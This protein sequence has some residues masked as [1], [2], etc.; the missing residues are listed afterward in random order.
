VIPV[1]E[2]KHDAGAGAA[3]APVSGRTRDPRAD[4]VLGISNLRAGYGSSEVLHG[5]DLTVHER[6]IV[7]L[8]GANGAGKTTLMRS[9]A[10][11][12]R[13]EGSRLLRGEKLDGR[14]PAWVA[15]RG[16]ASVPQG[17]GTFNELSVIDNLRLGSLL[18]PAARRAA[19]VD[20]WLQRFP[21]LA[22]QRNAAAGVLSGGEQQMLAIA[23]AGITEPRILLCDEPSLGLSPAMTI[24]IFQAFRELNLTLGLSMLIVEQNARLALSVA[25]FA[26]VLE[27]GRIAW[28][29]TPATLDVGSSLAAAYLGRTAEQA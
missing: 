6:E 3:P 17:R 22:E 27:T 23:R 16:I 15:R 10:G 11:E 26:Y 8:L 1:E 13:S 19:A 4:T 9:I 20:S 7:V 5:L 28:S 24:Q 25:N 14:A 2:T 18:L 29:G 12:L 21:R